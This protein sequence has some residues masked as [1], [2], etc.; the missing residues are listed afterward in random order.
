LVSVLLPS[1][2]RARTLAKR[3][4]C[5]VHLR[6]WGQ[7]FVIYG[8]DWSGE[9]PPHTCLGW[10]VFVNALGH[11]AH[12]API[13]VWFINA[14]HH[15]GNYRHGQESYVC[16]VVAERDPPPYDIHGDGRDRHAGAV[17]WLGDIWWNQPTYWNYNVLYCFYQRQGADF[18]TKCEDDGA[19]LLAGDMTSTL[20]WKRAHLGPDGG[21]EGGNFLFLD[22][23]AEWY[24]L[25]RLGDLV[26]GSRHAVPSD[27]YHD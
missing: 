23:H 24:D 10:P 9:L 26:L 19:M 25:R 13:S 5:T 8:N 4:L 12:G 15:Y 7:L 18:P 17:H 1:L 14:M 21:M 20:E 6:D 16:P 27:R 2:H 22:G 11:P 3:L